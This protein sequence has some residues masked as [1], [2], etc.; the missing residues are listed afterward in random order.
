[1]NFSLKK[2][3]IIAWK[4]YKTYFTSPIAYIMIAGFLMIMGW[5]FFF[6][7]SHFAAQSLQYKQMGMGKP[8]SIV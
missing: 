6:S 5:M 3:W 7:L 8:S 2:A 4:D 1:M